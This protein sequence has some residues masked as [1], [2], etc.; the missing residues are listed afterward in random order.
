MSYRKRVTQRQRQVI[1]LLAAGYTQEQIAKALGVKL[2]TVQS[3]LKSVF[4]T[5]GVTNAAAAID[6][7]WRRGI[8]THDQDEVHHAATA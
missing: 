7:C 3:H 1:R 8:L 4:T 2:P 6:C 5:L